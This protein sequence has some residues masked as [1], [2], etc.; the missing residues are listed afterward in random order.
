MKAL[1]TVLLLATSLCGWGQTKSYDISDTVN[2]EFAMKVIRYVS[3][4]VSYRQRT[5]SDK[6]LW[7]E[8]Y[9]SFWSMQKEFIGEYIEHCKQDSI[10]VGSNAGWAYYTRDG[11]TRLTNF[12]EIIKLPSEP[13]FEGYY[14]W[15]K[16]L[17][18]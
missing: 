5:L 2:L 17:L 16:N 11:V 1:L 18:E 10:E 13:T 8:D 14:E 15:L 4:T 7:D 3:D 9:F 6:V 12:G